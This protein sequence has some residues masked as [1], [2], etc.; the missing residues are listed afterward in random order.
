MEKEGNRTINK[1]Y[2]SLM[3]NLR[4]HS[5]VQFWKLYKA[6]LLN[7]WRNQS[8]RIVWRVT[9]MSISIVVKFLSL[10][11]ILNA[12]FSAAACNTYL[13]ISLSGASE[14]KISRQAHGFF[15]F[16]LFQFKSQQLIY[17]LLLD[18][19]I[20]GMAGCP[21]PAPLTLI[22]CMEPFKILTTPLFI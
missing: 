6:E 11:Y 9:I 16:Y 10:V 13:K 19:Q 4:Y 12:T 17:T 8:I 3:Q 14:W 2:D 20:R 18:F 7:R 15:S 1:S 22:D 21:I 5:D